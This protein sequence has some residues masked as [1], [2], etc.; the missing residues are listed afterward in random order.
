MRGPGTLRTAGARVALAGA[1]AAVAQVLACMSACERAPRHAG[2]DAVA[3][4]DAGSARVAEVCVGAAHSCARAQDGRVACWGD[5]AQGQVGDPAGARFDAPHAVEGLPLAAELRCGERQTCVRTEAGQIFCR[6]QWTRGVA[7]IPLPAPA[8]SFVLNATGGCAIVAGARVVCWQGA[9]DV[10]MVTID[11]AAPA[12]AFAIA[13]ADSRRVC[14]L[15]TDA[16]PACFVAP[17]HGPVPEGRVEPAGPPLESQVESFGDLGG[18]QELLLARGLC[19]RFAGGRVRCRDL[20]LAS[21]WSSV[22]ALHFLAANDRLACL[23]GTDGAVRC[24][25]SVLGPPGEAPA[26][27]ERAVPA[28]AA[29]LSLSRDHGCAISGERIRCWGSR[30]PGQLGGLDLDGGGPPGD[31]ARTV[32]WP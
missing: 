21:E 14:V 30:D 11:S 18:A 5:N 3:P 12:T 4:A 6:G 15:R 23:R 7:R 1:A 8:G 31:V 28:D 20:P 9:G 22:S 13:P 10:A 25:S 17:L 24:A 19:A 27:V 32:P 16:P 2:P 29:S 26:A